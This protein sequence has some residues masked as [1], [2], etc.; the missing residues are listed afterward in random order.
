MSS[1]GIY[2]IMEKQIAL[3]FALVFVLGT[4]YVCG[5]ATVFITSGQVVTGALT[6]TGVSYY[7]IVVD[8]TTTVSLEAH[9][10]QTTNSTSSTTGNSKVY[11]RWNSIPTVLAFDYVDQTLNLPQHIIS[12][13]PPLILNGTYYFSTETTTEFY[14]VVVVVRWL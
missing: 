12:L 4:S 1:T 2:F 8:N 14:V 13:A 6:K 11:A 3:L 9:L 7:G 5:Q 10:N